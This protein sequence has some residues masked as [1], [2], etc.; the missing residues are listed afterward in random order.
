MLHCDIFIPAD[1]G[2][3]PHM[4]LFWEVPKPVYNLPAQ[5]YMNMCEHVS[6]FVCVCVCVCECV[7]MCGC[8]CERACLLLGI[9]HRAC[10]C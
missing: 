3:R 5:D 2:C 7:C 10:V 8:V 6:V 9:E 1:D 4:F